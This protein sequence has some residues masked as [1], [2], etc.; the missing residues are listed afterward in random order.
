MK[1]CLLFPIHPRSQPITNNEPAINLDSSDPDLDLNAR[2]RKLG[3]VIPNPTLSHSSTFNQAHGHLHPSN[4]S[5]QSIFPSATSPHMAQNPALSLLA[6]RER[7]AGE[8]EEEFSNIG[9]KGAAGRLFLDV[10]TVRQALQMREKGIAAEEIEE[11]LGLARG[12][13]RKLGA[14]GVVGITVAA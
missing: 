3:P 5:S 10:L 9:R 6:A 8:A 7:L 1:V 12:V 13:M 14:K 11:E 4:S 2:A